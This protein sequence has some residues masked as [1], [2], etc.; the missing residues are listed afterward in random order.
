LEND[1]I[2]EDVWLKRDGRT[3]R[4]EI[5]IPDCEAQDDGTNVLEGGD[6]LI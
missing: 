6:G 5:P 3:R 2:E 4:E 1:K